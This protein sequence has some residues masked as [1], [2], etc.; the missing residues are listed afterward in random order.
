MA[1]KWIEYLKCPYCGC[2]DWIK[3]GAGNFPILSNSE[4]LG[5]V[6]LLVFTNYKQCCGCGLIRQ[7]PRMDDDSLDDFYSTGMY[8]DYVNESKDNQTDYEMT[9]YK[10]LVKLVPKP[11]PGDKLLD[12]GC[13]HGYLLDLAEGYETLGVE[14]NADYVT[15]K[16]PTVRNLDEVSGTWNVITCLHVLEHVPEPWKMAKRLTELLAPDG[17]LFIETPAD[18]KPGY[19]PRRLPHIWQ[20]P[21]WIIRQWFK[22]LALYYFQ[23]AHHYL[24]VF[25]K[26]AK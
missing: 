15:S 22:P 9:R 11:K 26:A 1:I 25:R 4:I 7:S 20:I 16:K 6:P 2:E 21:P 14:P 10:G 18:T 12:V 19:E 5:G 17:W 13:S 24:H 8:R 23:D 3:G